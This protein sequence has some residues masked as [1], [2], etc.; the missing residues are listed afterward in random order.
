MYAVV[1][2][3]GKQYRVTAG[4]VIR[5]EKLPVEAGTFIELDQVLMLAGDGAETQIGSPRIEGAAVTAKV[6]EQLR[7]ETV[8]V[9]KKKRRHNYR[10]KNGHRQHLTVLRIAEIVAPGA[11]RKV[12]ESDVKPA[13]PRKAP[14][15]A[16]AVG[17]AAGAAEEKAAPKKAAAKKTAAKAEGASKPKAKAAPKAGAK[18][19]AKAK[20]SEE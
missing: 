7:D 8:I 20:K 15:A 17:E 19:P 16:A 18:K 1:K 12:K 9:F 4:D 10:R 14:A 13:R 5:V 3:G 11:E 2:T 6:L